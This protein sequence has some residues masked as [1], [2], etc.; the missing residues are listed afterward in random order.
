MRFIGV[1][2]RSRNDS[3]GSSHQSAPLRWAT[4]HRAWKHGAPCTACRHSADWLLSFPGGSVGLTSSRQLHLSLPLLGGLS[5]LW[6]FPAA[7]LPPTSPRLLGQSEGSSILLRR[8]GP[9]YW[10]CQFQ[11]ILEV[12]ETVLSCL[13]PILTE[14]RCK[15]EYLTSSKNMLCYPRRSC[16]FSFPLILMS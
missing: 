15:M 13:L 8:E 3:N 11:E 10:V 1:T 4:T 14:P 7:W 5:G 16:C 12:A 6:H 9:T 2:D